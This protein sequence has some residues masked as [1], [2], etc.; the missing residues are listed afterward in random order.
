[1]TLNCQGNLIDLNTRHVM[2]VIN[3]TPDSFYDGGRIKS[4]GDLLRCAERH[5]K[6][7]AS[8]LDLGGCSSRPGALDIGE[9]EEGARVIAAVEAVRCHFPQA[10]IS[11]DTFRASI[12]ERAVG[13]G[14]ALINDISA[15]ERDEAMFE[16]VA[17]LQVPYI[18]MHMRGTPQNMQSLAD[19]DD[20]LLTLN[21]YFSQKVRRLQA[22]GVN[23]IILDPGFGFA[24]T[25]AQNYLLLRNLPLLYYG[26]LPIL[27]GISRKSMVY[28]PLDT[29][30]QGAL[31]GTTAAHV[32]ALQQGAVILRVHDV[33]EAVEA[34]GVFRGFESPESLEE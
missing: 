19:Y 20:V 34:I 2:G 17:K 24:K 31:N 10:L 25:L 12:A 3:L 23:D 28:K 1:M 4:D 5:L 15:G 32:L 33:R 29:G 22:L 27:V 11:I 30:P 7:G 8:F 18:A 16:T 26:K 14:A 13:A 9:E 21:L 6:A